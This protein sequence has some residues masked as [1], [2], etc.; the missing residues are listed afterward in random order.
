MSTLDDF[1]GNGE[2]VCACGATENLIPV[3]WDAYN[4]RPD[5]Y[6]CQSCR[7]KQETERK[8]NAEHE[9]R[10]NDTLED[11]TMEGE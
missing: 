11:T 9:R 6:I 4:A 7:D 8:A 3:G 10:L 2:K 5:L 1:F